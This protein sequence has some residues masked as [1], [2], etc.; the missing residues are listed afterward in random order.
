MDN[1]TKSLYKV[2]QSM[3]N[4][5]RLWALS[6]YRQYNQILHF[7]K[8]NINALITDTSEEKYTSDCDGN[9]IRNQRGL[10]VL[11]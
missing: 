1:R 10:R 4:L 7:A 2:V 5:W 3:L 8:L 6:K 9:L 11:L